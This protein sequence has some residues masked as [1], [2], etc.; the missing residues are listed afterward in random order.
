M[1]L[2]SSQDRADMVVEISQK[3]SD[4][5]EIF[6]VRKAD[7]R[8][9]VN[10]ADQWAEDNAASYNTAL[11]AAFR[12]TATVQQKAAL[13]MYVIKKRFART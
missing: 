3:L 10:A 2:L 4:D 8:A 5:R 9:A 6:N 13:L 1:A 11:P 12:T 7:L